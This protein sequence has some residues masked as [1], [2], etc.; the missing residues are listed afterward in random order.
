MTRTP[1]P[2]A[3]ALE[4]RLLCDELT[5]NVACITR[6]GI[7]DWSPVDSA[8]VHFL[9]TLVEWE[10]N[11]DGFRWTCVLCEF[12]NAESAARQGA[13]EYSAE[14]DGEGWKNA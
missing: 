8:V 6:R 10:T 7:A 1:S 14:R 4:A 3:P 12:A 13:Y 5:R 9:R 11:P 2:G